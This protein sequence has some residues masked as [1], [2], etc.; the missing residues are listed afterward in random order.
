MKE[1]INLQPRFV[2][3]KLLGRRATFPRLRQLL[4][5]LTH[6][7]WFDSL[8]TQQ[9]EGTGPGG[10]G[11]MPSRNLKGDGNFVAI[12]VGMEDVGMVSFCAFSLH[13]A[14]SAWSLQQGFAHMQLKR[15]VSGRACGG[16][17]SPERRTG[18]DCRLWLSGKKLN[19]SIGK[20][21][22]KKSV[23]L[24]M[25]SLEDLRFSLSL[26]TLKIEKR[27]HLKH[28]IRTVSEHAW[29]KLSRDGVLPAIWTH[30]CAEWGSLTFLTHFHDWHGHK[31]CFAKGLCWVHPCW[32]SWIPRSCSN[33]FRARGLRIALEAS[34]GWMIGLR[35]GSLMALKNNQR[36]AL[37]FQLCLQGVQMRNYM[38]LLR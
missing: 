34:C 12:S 37:K 23:W 18:K 1:V 21:T 36:M 29:R 13:G 3:C 14:I 32:S 5:S 22:S 20:M 26:S 19:C 27:T 33:N 38:Q 28:I 10:R 15:K 9:P 25:C 17:S 31:F 6:R 7:W 2:D 24:P 4:R 30:G 8:V 35:G 16:R 11:A